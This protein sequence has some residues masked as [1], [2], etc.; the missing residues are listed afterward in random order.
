MQEDL[1]TLLHELA[2]RNVE[3]ASCVLASLGNSIAPDLIAHFQGSQSP[4]V[5]HAIVRIID[6]F[7]TPEILPF[8]GQ[9]LNDHSE[10]VWQAAIDGLVSQPGTESFQILHTQLQ[11]VRLADPNS[12]QISFLEEA[13][14]ELQKPNPFGIVK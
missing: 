10:S 6:G 8:L 3:N 11:T 14:T 1:D 4:K 13:I 9:A 12:K 2:G 7:R 5:R